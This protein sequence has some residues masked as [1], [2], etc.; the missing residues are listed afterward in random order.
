MIVDLANLIVEIIQS[1]SGNKELVKELKDM[2][3]ILSFKMRLFMLEIPTAPL[4]RRGDKFRKA[5]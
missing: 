5:L 1:S 3:R 4:R 2:L